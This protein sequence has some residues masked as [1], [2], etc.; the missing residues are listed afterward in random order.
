[1]HTWIASHWNS[2]SEDRCLDLNLCLFRFVAAS[3][4]FPSFTCCWET[5]K[6]TTGWAYGSWVSTECVCV[7]A[8]TQVFMLWLD[9]D[10]AVGKN[11]IKTNSDCKE[12]LIS[13]DTQNCFS[14]SLNKHTDPR[15]RGSGYIQRKLLQKEILNIQPTK[16][17]LYIWNKENILVSIAF[18]VF[19]SDNFFLAELWRL[20]SLPRLRTEIHHRF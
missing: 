8:N 2:L 14:F 18:A 20:S 4:V 10:S 7:N 13:D 5:L 17:N 15:H 11:N 6:P 1:M 19:P 3:S 16:G 9:V 12:F